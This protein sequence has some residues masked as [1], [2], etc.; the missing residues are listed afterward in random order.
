MPAPAFELARARW[1]VRAPSITPAAHAAVVKEY[2]S[3]DCRGVSVNVP[4]P[5]AFM[6]NFVKRHDPGCPRCTRSHQRRTVIDGTGPNC[7]PNSSQQ[8]RNSAI[9]CLTD[10]EPRARRPGCASQLLRAIAGALGA[11]LLAHAFFHRSA[12]ASLA[13]AAR[14]A[15]SIVDFGATP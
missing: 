6:L 12:I 5:K 15:P 10:F 13:Y 11:V 1:N 9:R 14:G 7:H 4:K 8:H 2:R 3:L